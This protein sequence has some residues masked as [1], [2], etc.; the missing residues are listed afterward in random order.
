MKEKYLGKRYLG[1]P[2]ITDRSKNSLSIHKYMS[3][4]IIDEDYINSY[5]R[6]THKKDYYI[7]YDYASETV[8]YGN[9]MTNDTGD[10]ISTV[11]VY[12]FDEIR[13]IMRDK[14]IDTIL[15]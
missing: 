12:T 11:G 13:S 8:E 7:L 3:K 9:Y 5:I 10:Y 15:K 6:D 4:Y 1:P 2:N 14:K